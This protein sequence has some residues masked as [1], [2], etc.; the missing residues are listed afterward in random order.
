DLGPYLSPANLALARVNLGDP[1]PMVRIGAL[2]MLGVASADLRWQLASPL[3]G[4]AVRGVRTRAAS[5]LA[6]IPPAD[7]PESARGRLASATD[8]FV[9]TQRLN[10]DRP[11]SRT[12]LGNFYAQ[13]GQAAAAEAEYQTALRLNPQFAPAAANLADLYRQLG[14]DADGE[15]VLRA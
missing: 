9:A 3:L 11:E 7:V 10:A 12:S 2:D 6:D 13:R 1:D 5:L 8:E 4:D 14:R 15:T